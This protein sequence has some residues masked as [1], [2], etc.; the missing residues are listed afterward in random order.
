MM[1]SAGIGSSVL[2]LLL[3]RPLP[4]SVILVSL[5]ALVTPDSAIGSADHPHR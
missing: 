1:A 5:A 2:R 4:I 3:R